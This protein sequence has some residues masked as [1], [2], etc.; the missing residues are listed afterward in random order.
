MFDEH[1]TFLT[2]SHL[3][4][5]HAAITSIFVSFAVFVHAMILK[6]PPPSP[7]PL[8]TPSLTFFITTWPSLRS[9]GSITDP[10]LSC[11]CCCQS[12]RIYS[13]YS[14]PS[15]SALVKNNPAHGIKLPSLTY[16]LTT[17][18]HSYLQF[19]IT[20]SQFSTSASSQ[21]P[22]FI[23]GHTCSSTYVI[24]STNNRSG[25]TCPPCTLWFRRQWITVS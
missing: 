1:L 7:L 19:C 11:T 9:P 15:V 2:R 5:N 6:Q 10:K 25:G 8:F 13:H 14:H 20:S 17:I 22:L 3:S 23:F 16:K 18:Q 21:H 4:P 12:S 24:F